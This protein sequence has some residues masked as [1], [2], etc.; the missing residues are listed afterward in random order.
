MRV[1]LQAVAEAR[2]SVQGQQIAQIGRGVLAFVGISPTDGSAQIQKA[3]RKIAQLKMVQPQAIQPESESERVNLEDSGLPV[4]LVSQFTLYADVRKG[5][6]PGFSHAAPGEVARPLF[7]VLADELRTTWHVP[8]FTGQFGA[9][10]EVSL[11]NDG[12]F[13]L[14]VE[15]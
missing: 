12:P 5:K 8:V 13:T 1:L 14:W 9:H 11:L 7:D 4:L 6:K 3:A 2:V 10:M 15:V